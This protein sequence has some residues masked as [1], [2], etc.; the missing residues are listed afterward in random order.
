MSRRRRHRRGGKNGKRR[1]IYVEPHRIGGVP[2]YAVARFGSHMLYRP[3]PHIEARVRTAAEQHLRAKYAVGEYRDPTLINQILQYRFLFH[4]DRF[5]ALLPDIASRD[6]LQFLLHQY[7]LTA[8]IADEYKGGRLSKTE[9]AYWEEI[10]PRYRRALKFCCE[11]FAL[12][13]PGEDARISQSALMNVTDEF[14]IHAEELVDLA[15]L[16]DQTFALFPDRTVYTIYPPGRRFYEDLSVEGMTPGENQQRIRVDTEHREKFVP[17]P[18]FDR[19]S[20]AH[21]RYLDPPMKSEIG[22]SYG[23]AMGLLKLAYAA[24]R[25]APGGFPVLFVRKTD[26]ID[27]LAEESGFPRDAVA[28]VLAGFTIT[29]QLMD[30]EGRAIW[31]PKQEYRAFRRGMIEFPHG[32]GLHL[33]WSRGFFREA[34]VQLMA[35]PAFQQFPREWRSPAVDCALSELANQAGR[36]FESV[37]A[38]N[39]R[40]IGVQV[41]RSCRKQIGTGSSVVAIPDEVGDIDVL[42]YLPTEQALIVAECKMAFSGPDPAHMRQDLDRFVRGKRNYVEQLMRKLEW[43]R[44]K[45]P[46]ITTALR[47]SD[48]PP[49]A[50]VD[51]LS[52]CLITLYPTIATHFIH[53]FACLTITELMLRAERERRWPLAVV[54]HG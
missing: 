13:S 38:E 32:T 10:G 20:Q 23:E 31:K 26:L 8:N 14:V 41:M 39:L 42:G 7:D 45:W 49:N 1:F 34:F 19:D 22:I 28:H 4:E 36:W 54:P 16:S 46:E 3:R 12:S 15:S 6:A 48:L 35:S 25:P 51:G 50:P 29:K 5:H 21:A 17:R 43:I 33:A 24:S 18:Q 2:A 44:T 37:V 52:P 53:E 30:E 27:G 40:K 9:E 47:M 11:M